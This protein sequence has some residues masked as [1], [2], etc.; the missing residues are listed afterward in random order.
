MNMIPASSYGLVRAMPTERPYRLQT[1]FSLHNKGP[2][3][4]LLAASTGS[5]Q[6][7]CMQHV[8]QML[9][10]NASSTEPRGC[11]WREVAS[12]DGLSCVYDC[13]GRPR[14]GGAVP[15]TLNFEKKRLD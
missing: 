12:S 10:E 6:S 9:D 8:M 2:K 1:Y 14:D 7:S 11:R 3:R 4:T 5:R 13:R 15:L